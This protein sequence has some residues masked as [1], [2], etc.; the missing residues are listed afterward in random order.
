MVHIFIQARMTSSRLPGK[1]LMPMAR[2]P[3][4]VLCAQRAANT[5][6]PV[7]VLTSNDPSDQIIE[8]TMRKH[9]INCFRGSLNNVLERFI[10]AAEMLPDSYV[11]VRLTADNVVPDGAFIQE[12]VDQLQA[13]GLEYLGTSSPQDRLPYGLSAEA[14]TVAALRSMAKYGHVPAVME[15]VTPMLRA[16]GSKELFRPKS[17]EKDLSQLR[18]TIDTQDDYDRMVALFKGCKIPASLS[19]TNLCEK[20]AKLPGQPKFRVPFSIKYSTVHSCITLGTVQLGLAYGAT[21]KSGMPSEKQAITII[22]EAI[23]HGVVTLDTA[24]AYG[25]SEARLGKALANG[26]A[27][28]VRVI[29]KLSPDC[30]SPTDVESSIYKSCKNL[31]Q[32]KLQTLL[33]HRWETHK[34]K[35]IWDHLVGLKKSGIIQD[36][37]ASV[38]DTKELMDALKDR[39]VSLIQLPFNLLDWRWLNPKVQNALKK[40]PDI[41][42][43]ARS[44]LLQGVLISPAKAWPKIKGF[45]AS[46]A[47]KKLDTLVKELKRKNK[48]D[49]C[50]AYVRAQDWITSIVI[51]QESLAQLRENLKLM[52]RSPLTQE[53]CTRVQD[54]FKHSTPE[55]LLNPALWS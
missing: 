23:K 7:T 53:Q 50:L 35:K 48:T 9:E 36:L 32:T 20:L 15:H 10:K 40:R 26:L 49:L 43:H 13:K 47:V 14:F 21:N 16:Y 52:L 37:G 33:L 27:A 30:K 19:W 18:C 42:I 29:T 46:Q 17:L 6:L 25:E 12:L 41:I 51:G 5:G 38:Q 1:V 2:M 54:C 45:N 44:A 3:L 31:G 39:D 55:K 34:D 11:I 28:Q 8:E 24:R 4:V 22:H